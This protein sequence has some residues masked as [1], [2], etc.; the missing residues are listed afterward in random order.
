MKAFRR[1][2]YL[3]KPYAGSFLHEE[4]ETNGNF[5]EHF[6][7]QMEPLLR[8]DKR[9]FHPLVCLFNMNKLLIITFSKRS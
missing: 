6:H 2:G 4:T 3:S 9:T 1:R 8:S 5:I 7:R